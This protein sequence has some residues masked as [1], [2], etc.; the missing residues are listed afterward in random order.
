[1]SFG[2][3][4]HTFI[5]NYATCISDVTRKSKFTVLIQYTFSVLDF[6]YLRYLFSF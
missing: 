2:L 5:F 1:M 3:T 6:T 4:Q